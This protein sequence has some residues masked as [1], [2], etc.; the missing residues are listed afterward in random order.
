MM[1]DSQSD[2]RLYV[3]NLL[4]QVQPEEIESLFA[5]H[6]IPMY[7]ILRRDGELPGLN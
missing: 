5:E 1:A 6:D 2:C 4:Y 7:A 3:G